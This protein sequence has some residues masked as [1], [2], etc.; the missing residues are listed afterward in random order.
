M[1]ASLPAPVP[2]AAGP[3]ATAASTGPTAAA[4]GAHSPIVTGIAIEGLTR[5]RPSTVERILDVELPAPATELDLETLRQRLLR[6]GLF[7]DDLR[8]QLV[9]ADT[10]TGELTLLV[11]LEERWTLIPL[12]IAVYGSDGWMGGAAVVE[13]NLRGSGTFLIAAAML[14]G[15]GA[16]IDEWRTALGV[17]GGVLQ[18]GRLQPGLFLSA[19]VGEVVLVSADGSEYRRFRRATVSARA[20]LDYRLSDSV[21]MGAAGA[22]SVTEVDSDWSQSQRPP[23]STAFYLQDV[24]LTAERRSR[25][26]HFEA[27]PFAQA[28][29]R[30]GLPLDGGKPFGTASANVEYSAPLSVTHKLLIGARAT[31]GNAP[32]T[33]LP[34]LSGAG[35]RTLPARGTRA[36]RAVAAIVELEP[37]LLRSRWVTVTAPLFFEGGVYTPDD[38]LERFYGPGSGLR[39]YLARV[40]VPA[41]GF[42]VGYNIETGEPTAGVTLG[43]RL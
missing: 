12:P 5:T 39:L 28:H 36:R 33:E 25:V 16:S 42:T 31:L 19:G 26:G 11:Q 30:Q 4:A 8:I 14:Q 15:D 3:T 17:S 29:Y 2:A 21:T 10:A 35:F 7:V 13:S 37:A 22:V 20:N 43:M 32:A 1:L 23:Q 27:G 9:P 18:R 40:A 41:V 24:S 34:A 38:S 6:S